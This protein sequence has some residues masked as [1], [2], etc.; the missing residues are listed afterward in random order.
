MVS[1]QRNTLRILGGSHRL[2]DVLR[3]IYDNRARLAVCGNVK[4][5]SDSLGYLISM[6][7][8]E[9]ML[10]DG[11]A[12]TAHIG[13]LKSIGSNLGERN[14]PRNAHERNAVHVRSGKTR[15]RIGRPRT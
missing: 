5:L 4:R 12:D 2:L 9:T 13:F 8:E 11:A 3:N 6:L 7:N 15:N 1:P 14:L 10:S